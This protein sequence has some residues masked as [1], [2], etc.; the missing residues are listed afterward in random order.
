M[1]VAYLWYTADKSVNKFSKARKNSPFWNCNLTDFESIWAF[2]KLDYNLMFSS[3]CKADVIRNG[4]FEAN[5]A[6][7][8]LEWMSNSFLKICKSMNF[9]LKW[10]SI[11]SL[12]VRDSCSESAQKIASKWHWN[13]RAI[14]HFKLCPKFKIKLKTTK[15]S[16]SRP[17]HRRLSYRS[18]KFQ[19]KKLV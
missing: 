5:E 18:E 1:R 17:F 4:Y 19:G 6:F 7:W 12:V 10:K 13:G 15:Y 8:K 14:K 11:L 3:M 2:W 9:N 16:E